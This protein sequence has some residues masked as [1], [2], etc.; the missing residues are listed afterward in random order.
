MTVYV[1]DVIM[2]AA[3]AGERDRGTG[4]ER[5]R[6]RLCYEGTEEAAL[7]DRRH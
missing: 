1:R 2:K 4:A 3:R 5:Y 6:D 7:N